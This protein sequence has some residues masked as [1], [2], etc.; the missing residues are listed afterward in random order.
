ML[1][2]L[3]VILTTEEARYDFTHLTGEKPEPHRTGV[4]LTNTQS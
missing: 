4:I 2:H 3:F 1:V